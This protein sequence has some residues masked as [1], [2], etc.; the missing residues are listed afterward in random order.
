MRELRLTGAWDSLS[1]GDAVKLCTSSVPGSTFSVLHY[2]CLQSLVRSCNGHHCQNQ[3]RLPLG[4]PSSVLRFYTPGGLLHHHECNVIVE[5]ADEVIGSVDTD[6]LAK[7]FSFK[8]DPEDEGA[9]KMKKK[10]ETARDQLA[11]ALYQKG[12]AMAEIESMKRF[13]NSKNA[14]FDR[15]V[16]KGA[17][18]ARIQ[19]N[20]C[21]K[22]IEN[23]KNGNDE[24]LDPV[25]A[26]ATLDFR[27]LNK[28]KLLT[29][30][31]TFLPQKFEQSFLSVFP[32]L[33]SLGSFVQLFPSLVDLPKNI[34][35]VNGSDIRPWVDKTS[36][37][38]YGHGT[39]QSHL[40]DPEAGARR[41]DVVWGETAEV[42]GQ[43]WLLAPILFILQNE[44]FFFSSRGRKY[45]NGSQSK[46]ATESGYWKATGKERNQRV[47]TG[48]DCIP[49]NGRWNFN[50]EW[51]EV[52]NVSA[53]C[54]TSHLSRELI[55]CG[56]NK[57]LAS[58][59]ALSSSLVDS[60]ANQF[61]ILYDSDAVST[62]WEVESD[63]ESE[64]ESEC[65]LTTLVDMPLNSFPS[66]VS[67]ETFELK[68]K[69]AA[70]RIYV[71]V[72]L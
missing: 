40:G 32:A 17:R 12:L 69:A 70:K 25:V 35:R 10:M 49:R 33:M 2:P 20:K 65:G 14:R 39:Y 42:D 16:V 1:S 22:G 56:R 15:N 54:D 19:Q 50:K 5:A 21:R 66:T 37:L 18:A 68:I 60:D 47:G 28:R 72:G 34:L 31:P 58:G 38:R 26:E 24:L 11:E 63:D 9:E 3:Q 29:N 59:C 46:R 43:L 8:S 57:G 23:P 52:V 27:N 13:D 4:K 41:M 62:E 44:W 6:E 36:L 51:W 61:L 45:P 64:E 7:Y 55:N 71:D 53:H 67:K 30:F 48:E